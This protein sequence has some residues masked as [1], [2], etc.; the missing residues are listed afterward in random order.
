MKKLFSVIIS[1]CVMLLPASVFV[2]LWMLLKPT[3][4]WQRLIMIFF[5]SSFLLTI[6]TYL[7]IFWLA[8]LNSMFDERNDKKII[9]EMKKEMKKQKNRIEDLL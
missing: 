5:G 2:G 1:T 4:F 7:F 6:Q 3:T 9:M 8:F